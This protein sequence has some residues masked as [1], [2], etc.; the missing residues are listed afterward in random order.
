MRDLLEAQGLYIFGTLTS[1][2]QPLTIDNVDFY[3]IPFVHKDTISAVFQKSFSNYE[4]AFL[5]L[6]DHI[7]SQKRENRQM[8]LAHAFVNGAK[9]CESDRFAHIG[10]TDL[11]SK[12]IFYDIDYVALGHLHRP[13]KIAEHIR[14]SGSLCPYTFSET[15]AKEVVL[16]DSE[17]MD[18]K[19]LPIA[20]LHPMTT[21]AGSYET[22]CE[23]LLKHQE[24]YVKIIL[25]DQG[26]S[27]ELLE[28]F[29]E[30][31]PYLLTLSSNLQEQREAVTL[32]AN[33][34]DT[35]SDEA[36]VKQFFMDYF[37]REV[38]AEESDWLKQA[39]GSEFICG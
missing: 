18:I 32:Q 13:Q 35:L 20:P 28:L 8:V 6:T 37:N 33:D 4:Q 9:V 34:L 38:T 19:S 11:I 7:R 36:I 31:C 23:Q 25:E 27:F 22:V 30:R 3:P 2:P 21:I 29:K 16:I 12:D 26:I 10:G 5:Q 1:K 14:Y 15:A 24:D 39:K 17:T